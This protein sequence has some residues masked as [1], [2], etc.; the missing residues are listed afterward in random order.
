M[1]LCFHGLATAQRTLAHCVTL[2]RRALLRR[3]LT[4]WS[5]FRDAIYLRV[6]IAPAL[7]S[8][9]IS[10][11]TPR[12]WA[13]SAVSLELLIST[14]YQL[15]H[16]RRIPLYASALAINGQSLKRAFM[17]IIVDCQKGVIIVHFSRMTLLD[18]FHI[19][20]YCL[21]LVIRISRKRSYLSTL[22]RVWHNAQFEPRNA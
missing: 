19:V 15:R 17:S 6:S 16:F 12:P 2:P 1:A 3:S 5:V 14:Q 22:S 21:R 18:F 10:V 11:N 13:V 7:H 8:Q 4:N 20:D 9:S